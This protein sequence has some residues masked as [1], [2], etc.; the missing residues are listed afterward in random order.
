MWGTHTQ[1]DHCRSTHTGGWGANSLL[2]ELFINFS[3][4][5]GRTETVYWLWFP[6]S[7]T[8]IWHRCRT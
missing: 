6:G 1:Q 4:S 8:G 3:S 7:G 2:S 5:F